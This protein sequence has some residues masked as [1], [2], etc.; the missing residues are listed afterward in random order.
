MCEPLAV[1]AR[2]E[3]VRQ[4]VPCTHGLRAALSAAGLRA[5]RLERQDGNRHALAG[6]HHDTGAR[7]RAEPLQRPFD[8]VGIRRSVWED[9]VAGCVG[10]L[11][12]RLCASWLL[13][14]RTVNLSP[15]CRASIVALNG[16]QRRLK[17]RLSR[18]LALE[19]SSAANFRGKGRPRRYAESSV[20]AA[21]LV[22]GARDL[23]V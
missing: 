19:I 11:G 16:R 14:F 7:E 15:T 3:R 5:A 1:L 9:V 6:A 18:F 2:P 22:I 13:L 4:I 12:Q 10:G 20:L 21:E 8:G 23:K 17:R